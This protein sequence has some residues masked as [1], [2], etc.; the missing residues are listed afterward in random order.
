MVEELREI[1][2]PQTSEDDKKG[3]SDEASSAA[4]RAIKFSFIANVIVVTCKVIAAISSGSIAAIA[5]A[6]DSV[7]DIVS[8]S[9]LYFTE[10][11]MRNV[12][13]FKFP[14]GKT[15]LE[16]L[17]IVLFACVMGMAAVQIIQQSASRMILGF[18]GTPAEVSLNTMTI[19]FL[20]S[21]ACIKLGLHLFCRAVAAT[22]NFPSVEA[23]AQDH[24]ND[25]ALDSVSL[26]AAGAWSADCLLVLF[27]SC[28]SLWTI[29]CT[30]FCRRCD[31]FIAFSGLAGAISS[32]WFADPLG[33]TIV[34]LIILRSWLRTG[35]EQISVRVVV[36]FAAFCHVSCFHCCFVS[37]FAFF[38]CLVSA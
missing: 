34:G 38:S 22:G 23:L 29:D 17:G 31:D 25:V 1:D 30:H 32:M 4:Q 33:G 6:I 7:L 18:S 11:A 5:S 12:D 14:A 3:E 16:P 19:V 2:D 15:R 9:V 28:F 24:L 37:L 21:I 35:R 36:L 10:R 8:A 13:T 20:C 26:V 27:V